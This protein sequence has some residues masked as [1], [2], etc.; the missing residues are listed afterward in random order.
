MRFTKNQKALWNLNHCYMPVCSVACV[1]MIPW[2]VAHQAPLFMEFSRQEYW[3][4]LPFP[5]PGDLSQPGIG[6]QLG[7]RVS[8]VSTTGRQIL[9]HCS[10]WEAPLPYFLVCGV[11][12]GRERALSPTVRRKESF[13]RPLPFPL[14]PGLHNPADSLHLGICLRFPV[15]CVPHPSLQFLNCGIL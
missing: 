7:T 8:S 10:T 14:D 15:S 11:L 2:T 4:G 9:Y 6:N 12:G 1:S 5:T 13:L 3:S